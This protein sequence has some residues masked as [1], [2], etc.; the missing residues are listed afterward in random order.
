VSVFTADGQ[1]AIRLLMCPPTGLAAADPGRAGAEWDR[2]RAVLEGLGAAVELERPRPGL[3]AQA[4]AG[5]A[6]YALA[7]RAVTATFRDA[8][9]RAEEEAH[10]AWF[11]DHGYA[12]HRCEWPLEGAADLCGAGDALLA[13]YGPGSDR[14]AL[15]EAAAWLGVD[16]VPVRMADPA[17]P[18]LDLVVAPLD[19]GAALVAPRGLTREG[20]RAVAA[21]F[22]DVIE[23]GP[24][25]TRALAAHCLVVGRTVVLHRCTPRL[26]RQLASR[27]LEVMECPV[28]ALARAGGGP[29]R[30]ALRLD[31]GPAAPA[32][33]RP[34]LVTALR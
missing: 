8:G 20:A 33:P 31:G 18:R 11:A 7:D 14:R 26:G 12:V 23:L 10:E 25:E 4:F 32:A 15:D 5:V 6:G 13:G 27:G 17:L 16:V 3:P 29:R 21:H 9:R 24:D 2:L 28:D 19:A 30:L 22:P 1:T 34:A